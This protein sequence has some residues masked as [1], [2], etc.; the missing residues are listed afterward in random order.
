MSLIDIALGFAGMSS[1]EIAELEK[2]LPVMARLAATMKEAEPLLIQAKPHLDALAPII[3]PLYIDVQDV[4]VV[5][6]PHLDA[7]MPL[8]GPLYKEFQKAWPDIIAVT[9]TV[10][11][12]IAFAKS[13][14]P[15]ATA[16][17]MPSGSMTPQE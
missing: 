6:K 16:A 8:I 7:L 10:V 12:L 14:V 5:A 4:W 17:A 13:K 3:E 2:E 9:P 15:A 11:D 1:A